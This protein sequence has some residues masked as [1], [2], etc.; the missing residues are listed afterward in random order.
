MDLVDFVLEFQSKRYFFIEC[1][2]SLFEILH[3]H[4]LIILKV[5][6]GFP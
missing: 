2:F 5:K 3:K 4:I 6:I 1:L